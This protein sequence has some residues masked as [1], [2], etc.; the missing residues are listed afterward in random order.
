A[1]IRD[2][3]IAASQFAARLSTLTETP[4]DLAQAVGALRRPDP[5]IATELQR[6]L[7]DELPAFRRDGGFVRAGFESA[8]DEARALRDESRRVVAALQTR[9]VDLTG[10]RALKI[11]HN[12]VL[13]YFVDV[14]AQHGEKLLGAPLNATFIHRQT[15]AGQ[16]RFT[17]TELGEL[18]AKIASAA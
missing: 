8:L 13:G 11:K 9:Y 15:T 1:A 6:A 14:S 10:V 12:N 17:T 2:G 16:V 5:A 4:R 18:E 7:A 3:I